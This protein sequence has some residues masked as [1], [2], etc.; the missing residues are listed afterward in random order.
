[1]AGWL[2]IEPVILNLAVAL[3][4][5]LL[6]GAERERRKGEG[7]SRAPAGIRTFAVAALAGAISVLAGGAVLLA[8]AT[9][10]LS[11]LAAVAYWRGRQDDPGLT[12]EIALLATLM[13]GGL[14]IE[15]ADLAGG[16]A[17]T[18]ALLLAARSR[19]HR[20]V[21]TVLTEDE[22][23]DA[24]IFAGA[25]L[26]I[27]PLVP[28]RPMG[29]YG[30]LN[31]HAI[32]VI[33]LLIMAISAAGHLAVRLLGARFGLPLAG[34][35]SGF[36]S[37]TATIAAM[38]ARA[39]RSRDVLAAAVGGAVLSTVAT[40]VQMS[41]VLAITSAST[42]RV[43]AVPLLCAGLASVIYGAA[44]TIAAFRQEAKS[45]AQH[46]HAFSLS[47]ALT[48]ALTLS[49]ILVA[50]SALQ[51]W[52]GE[53]G[54]LLA[55]GLAGFADTHSA[56][57]SVA[58]LVGNGKIAAGDA[59]LPILAGLSTNTVS[60]IVLAGISGGSAFALR[61]VPGLILVAA[62]AWAGASLTSFTG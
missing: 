60:K 39:A 56:A 5:G 48:F 51:D 30:A 26:V 17:V 54:I 58:S 52:F 28:D 18:V 43:L 20:F 7:P 16:L 36:I 2:P 38:G 19:L 44:F 11:T 40:I 41:I 12:T 61:V 49:V 25:S 3:G 32:W 46:G 13:L 27:L 53:N 29:P 37:S 14:A 4:I 9:A 1:M 15:K 33:V 10:G 50:S 57:I 22:L 31:P 21:R 23:E 42:L 8:V 47:A 35:A 62:A 24:L 34:L 6:I 45:E 55:A 59:I